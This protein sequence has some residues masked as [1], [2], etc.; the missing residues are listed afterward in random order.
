MRSVARSRLT[1][2]MTVSDE[3]IL[4]DAACGGDERAFGAL[5]DR[6]RPGLEEVC[7]L[8]LGDPQRAGEAMGETVVTAWRERRLAVASSSVRMWLYRIA[9]DVCMDALGCPR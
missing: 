9:V 7:C 1:D 5:L 3:S 4:L 2:Q 8:M 6:Y